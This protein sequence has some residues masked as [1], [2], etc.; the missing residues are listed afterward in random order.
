MRSFGV[1]FYLRLNKRLSKQS[2]GWWFE[3]QSCPLWRH[4][5]VVQSHKI[6]S[7]FSTFQGH[8]FIFT[9]NNSVGV[10]WQS[11]GFIEEEDPS[12]LRDIITI[13]SVAAIACGMI[14]AIIVGLFVFCCC[15]KYKD[16]KLNLGY[17]KVGGLE[18]PMESDDIKGSRLGPDGTSRR[19]SHE[20]NASSAPSLPHGRRPSTDFFINMPHG[21]RRGS[22][23]P[24]AA[25]NI[26]T[27]QNSRLSARRGSEDLRRDVLNNKFQHKRNLS[28]GCLPL[29]AENGSGHVPP[30]PVPDQPPKE[31]GVASKPDV[32]KS[33]KP[34][35]KPRSSAKKK[36]PKPMPS[37]NQTGHSPQEAVITTQAAKS[38]SPPEKSSLPVQKETP[39]PRPTTRQTNMADNSA[40]PKADAETSPRRTGRRNSMEKMN[41]IAVW[42]IDTVWWHGT[43]T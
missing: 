15:K 41:E 38:H 4:C 43:L 28:D 24:S 33:P 11:G 21:K 5:N 14:L 13:S 30:V 40:R 35:I 39:K 18:L 32:Q 3:T 36:V 20:S 31:S 29:S 9:N 23:E 2:W 10:E 26:P 22:L 17:T 37:P 8:P 12:D 1:F 16:P 19:S 34:P 42:P 7:T 27:A 25:L 6:A